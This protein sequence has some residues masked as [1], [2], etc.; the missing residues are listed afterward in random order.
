MGARGC[1]A[2][3]LAPGLVRGAL[4]IAREERAAALDRPPFKVIPEPAMVELARRRPGNEAGVR[5]VTGVTPR[6]FEQAG[7]AIL[8]ALREAGGA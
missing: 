5:A 4:W 3:E 2:V 6:V 1:D 7:A 8:R